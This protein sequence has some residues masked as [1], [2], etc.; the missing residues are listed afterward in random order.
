MIEL[1]KKLDFSN[2][3]S[4]DR[5]N[6]DSFYFLF[7]FDFLMILDKNLPINENKNIFR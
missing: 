4:I 6:T 3:D 7:L 5:L 1:Q 2:Q